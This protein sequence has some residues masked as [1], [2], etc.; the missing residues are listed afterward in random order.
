MG[1]VERGHGG[2]H[3]QSK[4]PEKEVN[5]T[6][7]P[8]EK[9]PSPDNFKGVYKNARFT[10]ALTSL[11][12]VPLRVETASNDEFEGILKTFSPEVELVLEQSHK[13]DSA[14]ED[15]VNHK[16]IVDKHVFPLKD[17]VRYYA[18]DVDMEYAMKES[19]LTD[20]QI[21]Q[22]RMNGETAVKE[23]VAWQAD[24]G[25]Q[26]LSIE[27][28]TL[29]ASK[30]W[31]AHEMFAKNEERYG[32][33]STFDPNLSGY[34]TQLTKDKYGSDMERQAARLA[35]E[36]ENQGDSGYR[37]QLENGDEEDA[38]S[39]V[40]R[41]G[42]NDKRANGRERESPGDDKPSPAYVPP[43]KRGD[44]GR[45]YNSRGR[46]QRTPP[47][48]S[49]DNNYD[50]RDHRRDDR[51]NDRYAGGN[52]RRDYNDQR[53]QRFH[54][55]GGGYNRDD[56]SYGRQDSHGKKDD[57]N[58]YDDRR[59]NRDSR[60]NRGDSRDNRG[61]DKYRSQD[62]PGSSQD[63]R[64]DDRKSIEKVSPLPPHDHDRQ[65]SGGDRNRS[66]GTNNNGPDSMGGM[67]DAL[68]QRE[69]GRRK[70]QDKTKEISD[71]KG[72][73]SNFKLKTSDENGP[74]ISSPSNAPPTVS[75]NA[76]PAMGNDHQ[77][78]GRQSGSSPRDQRP[79]IS[80]RDSTG[81]PPNQHDRNS[82]RNSVATGP[83]PGMGG[84][85]TD[86]GKMGGASTPKPPA[87]PN[88]GMP[89]NS[90]PTAG[91]MSTPTSGSDDSSKKSSLN[92]NAKEFT[93]NP[94]AKE[95]TPKFIPAVPRPSPTPP[96]VQTPVQ[97]MGGQVFPH[98]IPVQ[99][100]GQPGMP[101]HVVVSMANMA[102]TSMSSGHQQPRPMRPNSKDG[103]IQQTIRADIAAG[104]PIIQQ[105][106]AHPGYYPPPGPPGGQQQQMY[107]T[108]QG[109]F[110]RPMVPPGMN[111]T[112][113]N[114]MHA[115]PTMSHA[116]VTGQQPGMP[117]VPGGGQEQSQ[118][119]VQTLI[120]V[121]QHYQATGPGQPGQQVQHMWSPQMM[122][123]PS[124]L[125]P[126]SGAPPP[127]QV[128]MPPQNTMTATPPQPTGQGA[129]APSPG[130]SPMMGYPPQHQGQHMILM[131]PQHLHQFHPQSHG[132]GLPGGGIPGQPVTS[133]PYQQLAAMQGH[134]FQIV[135]QPPH[136]QQ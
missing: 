73:H 33:T 19:F 62:R 14:N 7:P 59:D 40:V 52:N 6:P 108:P 94:G 71:L 90:T 53:D 21:S 55:R 23:L 35:A 65:K 117:L 69:G 51:R 109:H 116:Q 93:F 22:T 18:K 121:S 30:G 41:P 43:N 10:W 32:L 64:R 106:P 111:I 101:P 61:G 98:F 80:P 119:Q 28:E 100:G 49:Y 48:R 74:P 89:P 96:R 85:P 86:G 135:G 11:I 128:G 81:P 130:P 84:P 36:I 107:I 102:M 56:R 25:D 76:S 63:S 26:G 58:R 78:G 31:S 17:V 29:N 42:A 104:P 70:Q 67:P 103:G 50:D 112:T 133:L 75:I 132:Q 115:V 34:T 39:A 129:A 1:R 136:Q 4:S 2:V 134:Q 20:T 123:T 125:H 79:S 72:F 9:E 66:P 44:S 97:T 124:P 15:T 120:P 47:P 8:L 82:P 12:G 122:S 87:T 77:D 54:E 57:Y 45:G 83:P 110:V 91:G 99:A 3:K 38:F 60:D 16:S 126:P 105:H 13:V 24:E 27:D 95:F 114:M 113:M 92:P 37:A 68:P 127:Q 46:G 5:H 131:H 88:Q 118:Q